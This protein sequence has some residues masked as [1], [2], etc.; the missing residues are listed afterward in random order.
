MQTGSFTLLA[1]FEEKNLDVV[2]CL[3]K[4]A[5]DLTR[6][7][8]V[9]LEILPGSAANL[10]LQVQPHSWPAQ[11][12]FTDGRYE[13]HAVLSAVDAQ[14]NALCIEQH[15]NAPVRCYQCSHCTVSSSAGLLA[16]ELLH[17]VS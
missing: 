4:H 12:R 3:N 1:K 9:K 6:E 11:L 17:L 13:L 15:S 2:A 14:G 10:E 7:K 5:K 16:R 8:K